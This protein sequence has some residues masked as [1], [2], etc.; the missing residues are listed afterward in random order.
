MSVNLSVIDK[1]PR[2]SDQTPGNWFVSADE[3]ARYKDVTAPTTFVDRMVWSV[4]EA[5]FCTDEGPPPA[6]RLAWLCADIRDFLTRSGPRA[7][8]IFLLA[9]FFTSW[10]APLL[11]GRLPPL[12]RMSVRDRVD[13]LDRFEDGLLVQAAA[14]LALKATLCIVYFEHPDAAREIGFD[15]LCKGASR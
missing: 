4:A 5:M 3:L 7:R 10:V 6:A 1:S 8:W 15:G 9:L 11:V 2:A 13:A 12:A 14:I